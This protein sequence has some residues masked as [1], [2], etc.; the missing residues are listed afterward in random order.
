MPFFEVS[1]TSDRFQIFSSIFMEYDEDVS[2]SSLDEAYLD[3]T[4]YVSSCNT[5]RQFLTHFSP[6]FS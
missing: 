1:S 5:S 6:E 3:L 4:N 2:M